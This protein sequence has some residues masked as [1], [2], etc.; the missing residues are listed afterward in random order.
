MRMRPAWRVVVVACVVAACRPPTPK[1]PAELDDLARFLF[2]EWGNEDPAA[3]ADGIGTLE[4]FMRERGMDKDLAFRR[5]DLATPSPEDLA[6]VDRPPGTDPADTLGMAVIYPSRWPLADHVRLQV[7]GD[8]LEAEPS[9]KS[10]TRHFVEPVDPAC[11]REA[12]CEVMRTSNDVTRANVLLSVDIV[13]KKDFRWVVLPDGRKAIAARAWDPEVYTGENPKT[14]IR[15][16]FT[17]DLWI[18]QADGTSWRYQSV[19]TETKLD[20][21]SL[22][23]P[24]LQI[25]TVTAGTDDM[26][27]K[28]D[29]VIGK[30]YHG[31]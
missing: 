1:A 27:R 22:E 25:D 12:S 2:R 17:V 28:T 24:Q 3:M 6:D 20:P 19:Y 15:Q 26:F 30:R 9:A 10:Y 18:E 16:S 29:E 23:D 5:F 7:E 21:P 4:T 11:F 13:L 14:A 31:Q 8:L